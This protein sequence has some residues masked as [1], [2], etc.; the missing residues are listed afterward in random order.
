MMGLLCTIHCS[1]PNDPWQSAPGGGVIGNEV[2]LLQQQTY[3]GMCSILLSIYYDYDMYI[4]YNYPVRVRST[5]SDWC[6]CVCEHKSELF[7]RK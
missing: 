2:G 5:R 6:V 3:P 4:V 7:E 1:A